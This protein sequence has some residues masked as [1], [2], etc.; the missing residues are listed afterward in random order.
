M[1]QEAAWLAEISP[2]IPLHISRFFPQY[3]MLDRPKTPAA[4]IYELQA[5]AS[6]YLRHVYTG[7]V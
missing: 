3:K 7:N 1:A 2:E 5:V 6:E 4:V